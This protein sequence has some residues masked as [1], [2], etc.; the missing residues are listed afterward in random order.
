LADK[1]AYHF[2]Q[3]GEQNSNIYLYFDACLI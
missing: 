2:M 1:D 3:V